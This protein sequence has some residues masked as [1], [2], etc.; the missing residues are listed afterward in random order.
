MKTFAQKAILTFTVWGVLALIL[1]TPCWAQGTAAPVVLPN[2]LGS[3]QADTDF[4]LNKVGEVIKYVMGIL[5]ALALAMF[6]FGGFTWLTSGGASDK[7]EK[8]KKVLV[9]SVIGLAVIFS[10]YLLVKLVIDGLTKK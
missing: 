4:L 8:G 3:Q 7:I 6:I 2:P 10:S 5:G 9:W 1:I